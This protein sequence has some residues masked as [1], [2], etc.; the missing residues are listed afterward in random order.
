MFGGVWFPLWNH[1]ANAGHGSLLRRVC[2]HAHACTR[3]QTPISAA[4]PTACLCGSP[5]LPNTSSHLFRADHKC[6]PYSVLKVISRLRAFPPQA[7]PEGQAWKFRGRIQQVGGLC[8][9]GH[10]PHQCYC[11][12]NR[13]TPACPLIVPG[14][15]SP[16]PSQAPASCCRAE[17]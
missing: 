9:V 13:D 10:R 11:P 2:T 3:P 15:R 8:S 1:Q 5:P 16:S 17:R 12:R 7:T 6:S 14:A 4:R